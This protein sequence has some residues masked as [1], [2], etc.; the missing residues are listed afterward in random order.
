MEKECAPSQQ[1]R[2]KN[3]P[4]PTLLLEEEQ[5]FAMMMAE[6]M[7]AAGEEEMCRKNEVQSTQRGP[8][9]GPI[10]ICKIDEKLQWHGGLMLR[11]S[12]GSRI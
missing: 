12:R 1:K 6:S 7:R 5:Q 2:L 8:T 11:G 3:A 4:I 9:Q 10:C